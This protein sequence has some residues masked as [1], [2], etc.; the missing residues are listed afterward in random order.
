MRE[1]LTSVLM[2]RTVP[3]AV[4]AFTIIMIL[5][6]YTAQ[7]ATA[8]SSATLNDRAV[9]FI[10]RGRPERAVEMLRRAI[11]VDPDVA[12]YH[13][14]LGIAYEMLHD[15]PRG[16]RE[17]DG[18]EMFRLIKNEYR[19]ACSLEV[20]DLAM[21]RIYASLILQAESFQTAFDIEEATAAWRRCILIAE[22]QYE[23]K[24]TCHSNVQRIPYLLQCARLEIQR[25]RPD[26]ARKYLN[27]VRKIHPKSNVAAI[28]LRRIE[29]NIHVFAG[30]H[31]LWTVGLLKK[32]GFRPPLSQICF[33]IF[34]FVCV[35]ACF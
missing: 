2:R 21:A 27:R 7:R 4:I 28:L 31:K 24:P 29:W 23:R 1:K 35:P 26:S 8:L 3:A 5:N 30:D 15:L 22:N 19:A 10:E 20:D 6:H 11:L 17:L 16:D 12:E 13:L 33:S 9:Q 25:E 32:S 34:F 18:T 14:N